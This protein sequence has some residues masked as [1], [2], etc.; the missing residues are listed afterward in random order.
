[1][2]RSKISTFLMSSLSPTPKKKGK[3]EPFF[4]KKGAW[5]ISDN[6]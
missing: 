6:C 3:S 1:M 2:T 4:Q 5:A